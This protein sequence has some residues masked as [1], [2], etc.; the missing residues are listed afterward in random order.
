MEKQ[1][2]KRKTSFKET[3]LASLRKVSD[4]ELLI[5]TN[6]FCSMSKAGISPLHSLDVLSRHMTSPLMSEALQDCV[7]N[8][9]GGRPIYV[10]MHNH[11]SI[12]E[13]LYSNMI[14]VGEESGNLPLVLERLAALIERKIKIKRKVI[15]VMTYPFIIFSVTLAVVAFLFYFVIP[16]FEKLFSQFG[17]ELPGI[18][19]FVIGLSSFFVSHFMT[20]IALAILIFFL[21]KWFGKTAKGKYIFDNMKLSVPFFGILYEKYL[22]AVYATNLATLFKSGINI[23]S[24]MA[25]AKES[26]D[27]EKIKNS[28]NSVEEDVQGGTK[29]SVAMD[30]SGVMPELAVQMINVGEESGSLDTMLENISGI[31]EDDVNFIIDQITVFLEPLFVI[32]ISVFV[33]VILFAMYIPIFR[34]ARVIS[35]AQGNVPGGAGTTRFL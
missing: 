32:I 6:Y 24:A 4:S 29:L 16:K 23:I 19:K 13:P 34:M 8:L 33:A 18:T 14:R 3:F 2:R 5:F 20:L 31:Y 22:I 11:E 27:N 21:L 28:L 17:H 10:A 30:N 12:F 25:I 7:K 35:G 15:S 9:E 26:V 1:N